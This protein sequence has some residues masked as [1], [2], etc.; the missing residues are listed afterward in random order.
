M[1]AWYTLAWMDK[2]LKGDP[3]ADAR[4]LTNRWRDD[5]LGGEVDARP[6]TRT[7]SR[8]YYRSR[9]DIGPRGEALHV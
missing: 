1:V 7:C 5:S 3:T 6:A 8:R 4:L 2:E 9:L